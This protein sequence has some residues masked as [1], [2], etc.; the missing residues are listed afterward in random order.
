MMSKTTRLRLYI[1]VRLLAKALPMLV[2]L[3]G[4]AGNGA[5]SSN[6]HYPTN[7]GSV[8]HERTTNPQNAR[9]RFHE[10]KLTRHATGSGLG[11]DP[12]N[13]VRF[14]GVMSGSVGAVILYSPD[15]LRLRVPD[16]RSAQRAKV[17]FPDPNTRATKTAF[18]NELVKNS[19]QFVNAPFPPLRQPEK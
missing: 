13:D 17:P 14:N 16:G 2:F 12:R 15:L 7:I 19:T 3:T 9:R 11:D 5:K 1:S 18:A 4:A 6:E 10:N 8:S